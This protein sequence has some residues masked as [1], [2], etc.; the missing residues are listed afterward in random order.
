M[1]TRYTVRMSPAPLRLFSTIS[2][3]IS[4]Q[5]VCTKTESTPQSQYQIPKDKD[6]DTQHNGNTDTKYS[7]AISNS[8]KVNSVCG[9]KQNQHL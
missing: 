6:T 4:Q 8:I 2:N 1:I 3:S 5:C 7:Y 9:Q